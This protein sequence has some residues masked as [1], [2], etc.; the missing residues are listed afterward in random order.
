M[1]G[2]GKRK[3][4]KRMLGDCYDS[5]SVKI[6]LRVLNEFFLEWKKRGKEDTTKVCYQYRW[7]RNK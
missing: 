3:N 4:D 2:K 1:G 5:V 6:F 7:E